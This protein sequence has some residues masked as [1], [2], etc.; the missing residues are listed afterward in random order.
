[1]GVRGGFADLAKKPEG[2]FEPKVLV[3][4]AAA[5]VGFAEVAM[6]VAVLAGIYSRTLEA[7]PN[8]FSMQGFQRGMFYGRRHFF[9]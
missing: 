3:F 9:C 4:C 7:E 1:M 2:G 6:K 8:A 5:N